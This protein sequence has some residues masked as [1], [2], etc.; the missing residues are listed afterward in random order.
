LQGGKEMTG[1]D[2]TGKME[3]YTNR[4]IEP[5]TCLGT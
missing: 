5:E 3:H 4:G 2:M 1:I